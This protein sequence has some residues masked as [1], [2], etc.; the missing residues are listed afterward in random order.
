M[1][2]DWNRTRVDFAEKFEKIAGEEKG[3][4]STEY[5]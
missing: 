4:V 1:Q 5:K 3:R 2:L